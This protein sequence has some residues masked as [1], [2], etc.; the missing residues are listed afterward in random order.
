MFKRSWF[1]LHCANKIF[2]WICTSVFYFLFFNILIN[3]LNCTAYLPFS[4]SI[5]ISFFLNSE[6]NKLLEQ[7]KENLRELSC[8]SPAIAMLLKSL[9]KE[10]SG[11]GKAY[12]Y[13]RE[14]SPSKLKAKLLW[15]FFYSLHPIIIIKNGQWIT[16]PIAVQSLN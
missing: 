2:I 3:S 11:T 14:V 4:T 1:D 10:N 12:I 13:C 15:Q 6:R 16:L 7:W 5:S 8:C 9:Q